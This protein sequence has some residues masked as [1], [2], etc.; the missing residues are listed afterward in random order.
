MCLRVY[1]R[2]LSEIRESLFR[3]KHRKKKTIKLSERMRCRK[4]DWQFF[5]SSFF[6]IPF[7]ANVKSYMV[8]I[9]QGRNKKNNVKEQGKILAKGQN[10]IVHDIF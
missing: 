9:V 8:A 10:N 4:F 5:P 1:L 6:F 2:L 3:I 7:F